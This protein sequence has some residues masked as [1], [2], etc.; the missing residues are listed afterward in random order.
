MTLLETNHIVL[1]TTSYKSFIEKY[2]LKFNSKLL[3]MILINLTEK[4]DSVVHVIYRCETVISY[5]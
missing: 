4:S 1:C 3:K 5:D 2:C